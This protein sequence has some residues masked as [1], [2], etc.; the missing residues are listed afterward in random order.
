[1]DNICHLWTK[2]NKCTYMQLELLP[3]KDD[4]IGKHDQKIG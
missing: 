3:M 2:D 1:M 4:D